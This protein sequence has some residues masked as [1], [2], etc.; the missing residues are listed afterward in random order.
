[1]SEQPKPIKN[2]HAPIVPQ[3]IQDF[4]DR[5]ELGLSRYGTYLQP[6]NGR[7]SLQ[8]AYE[9]QLDLIIYLKQALI[10]EGYQQQNCEEFSEITDDVIEDLDL[11]LNICLSALVD[12]RDNAY[13]MAD[14]YT[15]ASEAVKKAED[16]C[17]VCSIQYK[18]CEC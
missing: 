16:W 13:C 11:K 17:D 2:D 18:K 3:V 9:E 4:Q 6:F 7:K 14:V 8:D 5:M 15:I 10:E 1:M 12:I